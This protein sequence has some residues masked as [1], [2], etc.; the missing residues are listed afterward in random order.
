M[1]I[2]G[3]IRVRMTP[4]EQARLAKTRAVRPEVLDA[5]LKGRYAWSKGSVE[6]VRQ[7]VAYFQ[8]AIAQDSR[9]A[10]TYAGL[11]DCYVQ[12]GSALQVLA[13]K[14]SCPKL[15]A[16]AK[17]AIELDDTIAEAHAAMGVFW[18]E[19]E[20]NWKAAERERK[21]ALELNLSY[22][23]AHQY[24]SWYLLAVGWIRFPL[25]GRGPRSQPFSGSPRTPITPC[26]FSA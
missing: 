21:R 4:D 1:D 26:S 10:A 11:A 25:S 14:E 13:P 5:Y 3:E 15:E 12:L 9:Y 19:H 24:F 23:T 6:A 8:E 22:P 16:A 18:M 20:R 7:A 2:A 17:K